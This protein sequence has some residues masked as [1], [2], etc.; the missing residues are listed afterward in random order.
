MLIYN[1]NE[2]I[3]VSEI[4]RKTFSNSS[5]ISNIYRLSKR[6]ST[7]VE[8]LLEIFLCS[9]FDYSSYNDVNFTFRAYTKKSIMSNKIRSIVRW[10]IWIIISLAGFLIFSLL[11]FSV[12]YTPEYVFRVIRWR[13]SDVCDYDKFPERVMAASTEPFYFKHNL[14]ESRVQEYFENHP[15]VKDLDQFLQDTRTQ[16]LIVI[17]DDNIIY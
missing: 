4:N 8:E 15:M 6:S 17:Q 3:F 16:E 12:L 5:L 14:D 1:N 10:F 11:L 13:N 7:I 9:E 2:Y